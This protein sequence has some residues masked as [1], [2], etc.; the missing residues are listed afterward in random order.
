MRKLTR[1]CQGCK[2]PTPF[3]D[4]KCSE[5]LFVFQNRIKLRIL[6]GRERKKHFTHDIP[7][8]CDWLEKKL[9]DIMELQKKMTNEILNI[10]L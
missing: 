3:C 8:Y 4:C 6:Y 2:K 10:E 1:Q 9:S 5:D 7:D